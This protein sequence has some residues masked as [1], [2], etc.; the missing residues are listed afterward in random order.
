MEYEA[1]SAGWIINWHMNDF[2]LD[3]SQ[4]FFPELY[5]S[6]GSMKK[7]QNKLKYYANILVK[8]GIL[9]KAQKIGIVEDGYNEFG[10]I[11]Q[12]IWGIRLCKGKRINEQYI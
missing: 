3:F 4:K 6:V 10:C 7:M 11:T 9:Q 12:T 5:S 2:F 8:K 1:K